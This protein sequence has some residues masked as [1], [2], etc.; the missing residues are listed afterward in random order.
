MRKIITLTCGLTLLGLVGC[1]PTQP[2]APTQSAVPSSVMSKE[3]F[4]AKLQTV[5]AVLAG[6][7]TGNYQL[8]DGTKLVN[9]DTLIKTMG[10][11]DRTQTI[12]H[13]MF[14]YYDCTDGMMQME[15]YDGSRHNSSAGTV[16]I[17]EVNDY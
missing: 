6:D 2:A 11:P 7:P 4:R 3:E 15:L 14:W 10:R 9:R 16:V 17:G 1:T 13:R 5:P 12:G 8:R